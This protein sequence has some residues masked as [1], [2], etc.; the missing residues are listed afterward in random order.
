MSLMCAYLRWASFDPSLLVVLDDCIQ[1]KGESSLVQISPLWSSP[2]VVLPFGNH[3]KYLTRMG[4]GV[5]EL[6][7]HP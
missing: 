6:I 4:S 1:V 5:Y 3:L 7:M 2:L